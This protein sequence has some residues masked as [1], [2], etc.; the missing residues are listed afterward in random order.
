MN[1]FELFSTITL[2]KTNYEKGLKSASVLTKTEAEKMKNSLL[3]LKNANKTAMDNLIKDFASGKI[4][5]TDYNNELSK[6]KSSN[7][8]IENTAKSMG[9][10]LED[11]AKKSALAWGAVA[12]AIITVGKKIDQLMQQSL[13]YADQMGDLAA[14]YGT[15]SEA[16]SEMAYVAT[17]AGSD[18]NTLANAMSMLYMRA[19]QDG[20]AFQRLGVSVKDANGN[21][22]AMDDLFW[23]T[24]YAMNDL[25]S[26]GEKSAYMFDLFGRSASNI[27][28][29]LRKDSS[30]LEEMRKR[31]HDLGIVVNQTTADFAGSWFDKLDELKLQGQSVLASIVAGAPDAEEKLQNFF[32]NVVELLEQYV[33]TFVN[34][35]LR[36]LLQISLAL[37]KTA[38][39]M[40]TNLVSTIID[41]ILSI[42]WLQVGLDIGKS[43]LEGILNIVV[44]GLNSALGWLGVDIPKVDLGVGENVNYLEGV[45]INKEYAVNSKT[46]NDININIEASG[47]TPVSQ[48]TAEKTAEALA[49]YID[50]ILGGK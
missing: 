21:F 15:N 22:K 9:I 23:E 19:K 49:P 34:F 35:S 38:P 25:D 3:E 33:P 27:G 36:L 5:I 30:E 16:I 14:K 12:T 8:E 39:S 48:D 13:Q 46:Q 37:I 29:I 26:E 18:V 31:A 20:E 43:I 42:N 2:D 17:Q 10:S 41:T 44:S 4:N 32:D 40:V 6:I 47:D 45:D 1:V 24:V 7:S 28:E 11:S 50:K